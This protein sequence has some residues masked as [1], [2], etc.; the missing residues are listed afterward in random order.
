MA[1]K[2]NFIERSQSMAEKTTGRPATVA[3][4]ATEFSK[5]P[6]TRRAESLDQIDGELASD[7]PLTMGEARK[8]LETRK[9]RRALGN[10]HE[11]LR[12]GGR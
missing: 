9:H 8:L 5:D 11:A 10:V 2:R 6:L 1:D 12:R 3:E 7:E 4:M